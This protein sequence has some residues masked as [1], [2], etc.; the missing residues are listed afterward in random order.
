M[1]GIEFSERVLSEAQ[2]FHHNRV[3]FTKGTDLLLEFADEIVR[4]HGLLR[5]HVVV[6][7]FEIIGQHLI[8]GSRLVFQTNN[9]AT[10]GDHFRVKEGLFYVSCVVRSEDPNAPIGII[11]RQITEE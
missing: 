8:E 11:A 5:E 3:T 4:V 9:D 10:E 2:I 7:E 1:K 6:K